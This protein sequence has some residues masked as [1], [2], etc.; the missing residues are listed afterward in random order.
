M[1]QF[2]TSSDLLRAFDSRIVS[3]LSN[4]NDSETTDSDKINDALSR[5]TGEIRS[6]CLAGSIYT[7]SDLE[8]LASAGDPLLI[9]LTVVLAMRN[10]HL[11]RGSIPGDL[12]GPIDDAID[13][14][15]RLRRGDRVLSVDS[16]VSASLPSSYR[17]SELQSRAA[18]PAS[19][20]GLYPSFRRGK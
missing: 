10:L 9:H 15:D 5:A 16:A 13:T 8:A 14:L 12:Q 4:D 1:S 17:P 11:R 3:R 2:A 18:F 7:N 6:A 20:S 19:H